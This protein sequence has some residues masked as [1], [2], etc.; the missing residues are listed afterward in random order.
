[1]DLYTHKLIHACIQIG[2]LTNVGRDTC[3][4]TKLSNNDIALLFIC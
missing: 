2:T 1:M 3:K 4:Q